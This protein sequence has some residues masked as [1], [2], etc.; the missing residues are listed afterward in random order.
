MLL[1]IIYGDSQPAAGEQPRPGLAGLVLDTNCRFKA[2]AHRGSPALSA[3]IAKTLDYRIG[4]LHSKAGHKLDCQLKFSS[5]YQTGWGRC[6][7]ENMEQ[8]WVGSALLGSA[9]CRLGNCE[10]VG[11]YVGLPHSI[12]I[13]AIWADQDALRVESIYCWG[14]YCGLA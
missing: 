10:C 6:I 2:H 1:G 8:M 5:M 9:S 3:D 13:G 7:G 4:L 12:W 14:Q 11:A